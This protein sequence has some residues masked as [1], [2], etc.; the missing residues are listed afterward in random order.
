LINTDYFAVKLLCKK[1]N[2]NFLY[3]HLAN[4]TI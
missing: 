1:L 4:I 2:K 3:V